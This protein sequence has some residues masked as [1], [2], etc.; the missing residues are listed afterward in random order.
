MYNF[1]N[2]LLLFVLFSILTEKDLLAQTKNN[3]KSGLNGGAVFSGIIN[4]GRPGK[5]SIR[6]FFLDDL[7]TV[8][9][10]GMFS[11]TRKTL[12][13]QTDDNGRFSFR[14]PSV[15][16]E[17]GAIRLQ[18]FG[19]EETLG[20]KI[21]EL[22][23][24]YVHV[25]N[26][27]SIFI[28]INI[29]GEVTTRYSGKGSKKYRLA[30][31]LMKIKAIDIYDQINYKNTLD[32]E[33]TLNEILNQ[34][35]VFKTLVETLLDRYEQYLS[36]KVYQLIKADIFSNFDTYIL[37]QFE[38]FYF[39]N[40]KIKVKEAY[41]Q[42]FNSI[43]QLSHD[44]APLSIEYMSHI[45]ERSIFDL[46]IKH[47]QLN[48]KGTELYEV[49]KNNYD[50]ILRDKLI[51]YYLLSKWARNGSE[52]DKNEYNYLLKDAYN[53]I[54]HPKLQQLVG[55]KFQKYGKGSL[56]Y[57]FALPDVHGNIVKLEDFKGK[58]VLLHIYGTICTGCRIF[59]KTLKKEVFAEFKDNS[60]VSFVAIS[61]EKDQS[62]WLQDLEEGHNASKKHEVN[63]YTDGKGQYHP[64]LKYYEINSVPTIFLID[65][66]SKIY[67]SSMNTLKSGTPGKEIIAMIYDALGAN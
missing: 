2:F 44:L 62:R 48:Y 15:I 7:T 67:N 23:D 41:N 57:N 5:D 34:S 38:Q 49:L 60:N 19:V 22:T 20:S 3:H 28:N 8:Y 21:I 36:P 18:L 40:K 32:F 6:L 52:V 37:R 45:L 55:G 27:D 54:R 53:L 24:S 12:F 65:K 56:A 63:L 11:P 4:G 46:R 47:N 66:H 25:E 9:H 50:G 39:T 29:E 51:T 43:D 17:V 59:A 1:K 30:D 64:Y 13:V 33:N 58:V 26:T 16:N 31:N 42:Y 10:R 35:K 14:L 61:I